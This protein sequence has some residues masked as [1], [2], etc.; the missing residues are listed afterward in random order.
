MIAAG[1][2]LV[3]GFSAEP[4]FSRGVSCPTNPLAPTAPS[5]SLH[6]F[7]VC[8]PRSYIPRAASSSGFPPCCAM[9]PWA[10]VTA[11]QRVSPTTFTRASAASL[12]GYTALI[13]QIHRKVSYP[14]VAKPGRWNLATA[15][16]ICTCP[17]T[18]LY[19]AGPQ[20]AANSATEHLI[21]PPSS[22]LY[23]KKYNAAK[24]LRR[25]RPGLCR[26]TGAG[27]WHSHSSSRF[28][29]TSAHQVEDA[30]LLP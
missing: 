29:R 2:N 24:P 4:V 8:G 6:F 9:N 19:S 23:A 11:S 1:N 15:R 16:T 17:R 21:R 28:P 20:F 5:S 27:G 3:I 26:E 18:R 7:R 14:D 22:A 30:H 13:P 25:P 10:N 12:S